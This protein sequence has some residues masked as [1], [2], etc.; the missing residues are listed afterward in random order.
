[1]WLSDTSVKRP[2]FA[3]VL[4]LLLLALGML[5]FFELN[6]REYPDIN[7]PVVSVSTFYFGASADVVESRVT[8]VLESEMSGIEGI[9]NISS[10]SRDG[11]SSITIEFDLDRDIDDATNDVR[12]KV[13]V[14]LRRLPPD[15]EIPVISKQDADE[16]PVLWMSFINETGMNPMETTDYADRHIIDRFSVISGVSRVLFPQSGR[17]SMRI[18]LDRKALAARNLT[19]IDIQN[20]LLSEN[21]ELPAGRLESS[22]REFTA[23]IAANYQTAEDFRRLVISRG[24]DGHFTRLGEIA[25]VEVA[26]RDPR[27]I[28]RTN[29]QDNISIGIIKQST[30]NTLDVLDAVK[31]EVSKINSELPEGMSIIYSSDNSLFIR[32][33]INNVY[34]TIGIATV[35]VGLVIYLFLGSFRAM[36][37]PLV[38]IPVCL[39]AAFIILAA[40]GFTVNL[41]TLLALVLSIGLVVDDSIVVLENI[42]R[43]IE[44][45]EVP[46]LAAFNGVRQVAFAVVATTVVLVAV[47]VPI[48]FLKDNV[49]RIFSELAVTVSAAVIFSSV[50]ALSLVPMLSSKV[51]SSVEAEGRAVKLM[52]Y[53]FQ[54]IAIAY[55]TMLSK[56]LRF[57]WIATIVLLVIGFGAFHLFNIIQREYVPAED[58]GMFRANIQTAE[59]TSFSR[60]RDYIVPLLEEPIFPHIESGDLQRGF[61]RFPGFGGSTNTGFAVMSLS[62]WSERNTPTSEIMK[63]ISEEWNNIPGV[64]AFT[65]IPSGLSRRGGGQPVQ[66]V[67]GGPTYD[68]LIKWRDDILNRAAE[69]PGLIQIDT[70]LK[71]TQPQV[72]LKI[73][74][75]RAAELGVSIQTIGRTLSTMMSDQ[76]VTTYIVDGE[77]YDVVL[78]AKED[79][80]ATLEDMSNIYVRSDRTGMLVPLT[81]LT[82]IENTA[83]PGSLNRYNRYRALTISANLASGYTLGDALNFLEEI[84]REELP[85]SA[86]VDFKGESLE[87]KEAS[88]SIMFTFA[89]AL[90]VVYLV[91][92]AQFESFI[93]PLVIMITV[94]MAIVGALIGLALTDNTINIYTQ[95]GMVMLV[96]IAAKNGILI[97]EFIN[98]LREK[99]MG[100]EKAILE[101]AKIRFRPVIMTTISTAIGAVP[102]IIATGAG[103]ASRSALGVVIFFG[104]IS[105]S[106]FT[107]FIVPAFYNLMA[108]NTKSR[109]SVEKKL[110]SLMP[111]SFERS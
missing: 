83:G 7:P 35:L 12:D 57:S 85:Q 47:F 23:R 31:E 62:P 69:Y 101:G 41:I 106:L 60:I 22:E 105:A 14:A 10:A 72:V 43:R 17:P 110:E 81:N 61:F 38:T 76:Q 67:I 64:R 63:S 19:V 68:V 27:N 55:E 15:A 70:D 108:K 58:Q 84:A 52:D 21:I 82:I 2:V 66:L 74:K 54:K 6:V 99:G 95:I 65:T 44:E 18:W 34:Y 13:S 4:S 96:G 59:G 33:A 42:H 37:I 46:L 48:V 90:F 97:V 26:E 24:D 107:L 30:A 51:L 94:P 80:R 9:K 92:A 53:F 78:Q 5:S 111:Q 1:M 29:G 73:N 87:F 40:F 39:S 103:S 16:S 3:A 75:D 104:V 109:N 102:L 93:H 71:E 50:L 91:L 11:T 86:Y 56:V 98:Q 8:Q 79:Q 32:E 45:G 36:L 49:G 20:T 88:G 100:F 89:I 77:E 25:D 28:F